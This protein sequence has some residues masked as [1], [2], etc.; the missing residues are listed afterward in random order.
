MF[1][2]PS[3]KF[4]LISNALSI[5]R[6][7]KHSKISLVTFAFTD[8]RN[9]LYSSSVQLPTASYIFPVT[10]IVTAFVVNTRW[11][12]LLRRETSVM[13]SKPVGNHTEILPP[14]FPLSIDV[15]FTA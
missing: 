15:K 14:S 5:V 3:A 2:T 4:L 12:W 6:Q 7:N 1:I 13:F 9:S 10:D 11:V 8:V